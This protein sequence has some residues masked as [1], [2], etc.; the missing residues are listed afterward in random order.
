MPKKK[1]V[2]AIE[3]NMEITRENTRC[4]VDMSKPCIPHAEALARAHDCFNSLLQSMNES[5]QESFIYEAWDIDDSHYKYILS[6][7]Y[8]ITFCPESGFININPDTWNDPDL[9]NTCKSAIEHY[10]YTNELPK[11]LQ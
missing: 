7:V 10:V 11:E 5:E 4:I 8:K 9:Y 2:S 6:K 3:N 1:R